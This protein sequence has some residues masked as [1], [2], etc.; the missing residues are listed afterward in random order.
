MQE[1]RYTK[2]GIEIETTLPV[3]RKGTTDGVP[4]GTIVNTGNKWHAEADAVP[5]VVQAYMNNIISTTSGIEIVTDPVD[6]LAEA[7]K[8]IAEIE[9]WVDYVRTT[10]RIKENR[11]CDL[12][13]GTEVQLPSAARTFLLNSRDETIGNIQ[14]NMGS[15]LLNV[16][17]FHKTQSKSINVGRAIYLEWIMYLEELGGVAA[18]YVISTYP[19]Q[20]DLNDADFLGN[21]IYLYLYQPLSLYLAK[22]HRDLGESTIKN[23]YPILNKTKIS[24][25]VERSSWEK[26]HMWQGKPFRTNVGER[27]VK[28][29]G[30]QKELPEELLEALKLHALAMGPDTSNNSIAGRHLNQYG[31]TLLNNGA[32]AGVYELRDVQD[33]DV[34]EHLWGSIWNKYLNR[35]SE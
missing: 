5:R 25:Q 3:Q 22:N 24:T 6:N 15:T 33:N 26:K 28:L 17:E 11:T 32:H 10:T 13:N 16:I 31:Q 23:A 21:I 29:L 9:I 8:I 19:D 2:V 14:V 12:E 34:P 18:K 20:L 35:R 7:Q 30:E 4:Y 27:I 1:D